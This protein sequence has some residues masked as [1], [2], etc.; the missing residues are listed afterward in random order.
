MK[1]GM[2]RCKTAMPPARARG[3]AENRTIASEN[4]RVAKRGVPPRTGAAAS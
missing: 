2:R 4:L 1:A 3:I